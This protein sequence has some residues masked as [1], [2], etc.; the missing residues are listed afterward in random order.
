MPELNAEPTMR[1]RDLLAA[2]PAVDRIESTLRRVAEILGANRCYLYRGSYH[3]PLRAG[4]SIAITPDSANRLRVEACSWSRPVIR[5]WTLAD[6]EY[7]LG[8]LVLKF[9]DGV[10]EAV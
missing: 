10:R 1:T 5:Y 4:W 6:D 2:P 8:E 3:F 9:V 7:R